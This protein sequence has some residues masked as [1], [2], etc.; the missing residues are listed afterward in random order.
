MRLRFS[1]GGL[2]LAGGALM[3]ILPSALHA[4]SSRLYVGNSI[5]DNISVIDL[6]SLK[7]I[8]DIHVGPRVH[9][10]AVQADGSRLFT[11]SEGDNTL[12]IFDTLTDKLISEIKLTGRPNQC[13]VTPDGKYVAVPIRDADSVDIVDTAQQRVVKTLP[14][15]AP[16]NAF[17]AGS[18]R[19]IFVSSMGDHA[20]NM[21]DLEKMDYAANIPTGGVPR[22]YVIT[23]DGRTMYAAL[24]D[25]HG[26]AMVDIPERRV[27]RRVEMPAEHPTP[28]EHPGEPINTLTHG[29]ALSP[30]ERE[31]WVTSLLD[32]AMYVYDVSSQKIVGHVTVG[33]GPNW[34][35]FSPD[36][37]YVCVSNAA[38]DDVSIIDV[39]VRYEVARLKVGRVPKRLVAASVP[40]GEPAKQSPSK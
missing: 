1:A 27:V 17:N 15:K 31:L 34:V 10:M 7:V 20:I 21:I 37:K 6:D 9:G 25:L 12:R 2:I 33:S 23:R 24:S 5:A 32:D 18:N 3:S 39:K 29:L 40:G 30:D 8:G 14:V 13:A 36:G 38:D 22:P 4:Q 35:A 11:T 26:F 28:H 16:H 19:Y